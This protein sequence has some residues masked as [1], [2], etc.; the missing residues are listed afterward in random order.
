MVF[1]QYGEGGALRHIHRDSFAEI[2]FAR[3]TK[4]A[5]ELAILAASTE[6]G[7]GTTPLALEQEH[8]GCHIVEQGSH[9]KHAAEL[10]G[11]KVLVEHEEVVAEVQEGL[12]RMAGIQ[13]GTTNVVD[14]TGGYTAH[15]MSATAES[16][17]EI[18]L[19]H[20]CKEATIES[21]HLFI[22]SKAHHEASTCGP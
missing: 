6:N 14:D 5:L 9:E 15:L 16:P 22:Y 21:A 3:S 2:L 8:C 19:L 10:P 13:G 20:V 11:G 4:I 12:A 17:A 7:L 1:P 18:D